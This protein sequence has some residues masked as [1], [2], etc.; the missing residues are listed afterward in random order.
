[1]KNYKDKY[2]NWEFPSCDNCSSKAFT[3]VWNDITYW[4]YE[5]IFR[6][7]KCTKCDLLYLHPR[8]SA[9]EISKYYPKESYWGRDVTKEKNVFNFI[10]EREN[11]FSPIYDIILKRKNT[12]AILDIGAGTGLFLS[13]F[14]DLGWK[15]D[16]VEFSK[17]AASFAKKAFK[18]GLKT[19]DFLEY[20]FPRNTYDVVTLN[21]ALE[22]LYKPKETLMNLYEIVKENGLLVITVPNLNSVGVKLFKKNWRALDVPKHLYHFTEPSL[23][24]MVKGAGFTVTGTNHWYWIHNYYTVFESFRFSLSPRFKQKTGGGLASPSS[25]SPSAPQKLSVKRELGKITLK[26]LS[27]IVAIIGSIT[28]RSESIIIYAIKR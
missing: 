11:A 26:S 4:E 22:H 20:K 18:I 9:K 15:V 13:K 17:E 10:R 25:P 5:G 6:I 27:A 19:G 14:K 2:N 23:K 8:P 7:V 1:M 21:M 12:G 16:G 28:G 24:N 3:I